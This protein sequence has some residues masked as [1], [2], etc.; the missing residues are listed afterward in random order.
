MISDD[1][2]KDLIF[3]DGEQAANKIHN[4]TA[5]KEQKIKDG[6]P[7]SQVYPAIHAEMERVLL[8]LL[9]SITEN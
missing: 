4:L 9:L 7:K 1:P 6:C 3:F 5:I 8:A 2:L